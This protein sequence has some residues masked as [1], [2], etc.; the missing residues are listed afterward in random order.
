MTQNRHPVDQLADVR[1]EIKNLQERE[2]QLRTQLLDKDAHLVGSDFRARVNTRK[3]MRLD[4]KLLEE[5]F[6]KTEV[7]KCCSE[8]TIVTVNLSLM[9][10]A[11]EAA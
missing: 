10:A 1:A 9:R 3:Q 6:G 11:E 5:K 8:A 2:A 7:A 4:R